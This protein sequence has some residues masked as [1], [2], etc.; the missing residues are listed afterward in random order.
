[1]LEIEGTVFFQLGPMVLSLWDRVLL[2]ED[3]GVVDGGGWGGIALAHNVGSEAE[4]DS[5]IS[6]AAAAGAT[7][8]KPPG[9][10]SWGGYHGVFCDPDGHT[11]EIAHNPGFTIGADG[12][13]TIPG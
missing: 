11:W 6:R 2:A 3:S 13:V 4:V 7:V 10:T 5:V 9:A 1:M 8:T 12:S